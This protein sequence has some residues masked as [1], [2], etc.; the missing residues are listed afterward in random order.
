MKKI[1]GRQNISIATLDVRTLR[2]AGKFE[3]YFSG[4]EDR[5]EMWL[6][7]LSIGTMCECYLGMP[8]SLS[9]LMLIHLRV[10][11]FNI[12]IIQ[13]SAST[14]GYDDNEADQFLPVSPKTKHQRRIF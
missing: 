1:R 5:H 4:E 13:V 8:T 10:A 3:L 11:P 14:S 6:H 2:P 7:F 12:T 9:R